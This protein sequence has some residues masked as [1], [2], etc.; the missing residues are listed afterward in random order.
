MKTFVTRV[1]K[2]N[3]FLARFGYSRGAW[4]F[5]GMKN[6]TWLGAENVKIN[7]QEGKNYEF[8]SID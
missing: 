2:K 3:L 5:T 1:I 8:T 7:A 4:R 6:K